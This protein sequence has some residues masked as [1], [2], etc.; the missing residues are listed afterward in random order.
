MRELLNENSDGGSSTLDDES[1]SSPSGSGSALSGTAGKIHPHHDAV[2]KNLTNF[3][4]LAGRYYD[5]YR[6]GV[7]MAGMPRPENDMA[8]TGPWKNDLLTAAYTEADEEIIKASAKAM[9]LKMTTLSSN[10]SDE[11]QGT[12]TT[13]PVAKRKP[14]RYGV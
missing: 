12:N 11:P 4:D 9:G 3:P 8:P 14:N 13:S 5:M 1:S 7:S 6:F 2:I 10:R